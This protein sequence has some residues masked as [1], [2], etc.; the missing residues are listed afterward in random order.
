[1]KHFNIREEIL[2][3]QR[4][5][6][7]QIECPWLRLQQVHRESN[8]VKIKFLEKDKPRNSAAKVKVVSMQYH[9]D[10]KIFLFTTINQ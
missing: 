9:Q 4:F 1:M 7:M 2:I 6:V 10:H 8:L 3:Y 5:K